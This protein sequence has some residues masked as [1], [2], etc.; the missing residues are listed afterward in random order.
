MMIDET[1]VQDR[2]HN[3]IQ[4]LFK[5]FQTI[6][7]RD[8]GASIRERVFVPMD[9]E[10]LFLYFAIKNEPICESFIALCRYEKITQMH[11]D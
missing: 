6:E 8:S 3:Q 11:T 2:I 10:V 1:L 9:N 7:Y 4:S 5:C